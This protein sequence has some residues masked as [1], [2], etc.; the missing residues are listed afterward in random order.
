M[1]KNIKSE[2]EFIGHKNNNSYFKCKKC[3]KI[4]LKLSLLSTANSIAKINK[5]ECKTCMEKKNIKSECDF[6]EIQDNKLSYK[7]KRINQKVFTYI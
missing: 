5:K 1:E 3:G 7:C 4:W 6:T 2:C